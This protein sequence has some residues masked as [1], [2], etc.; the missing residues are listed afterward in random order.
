MIVVIMNIVTFP[1][2]IG[3]KSAVTTFYI[4]IYLTSLIEFFRTSENNDCKIVLEGIVL[5][6]DNGSCLE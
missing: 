5:V 2:M 4:K 6:H 1:R 3:F